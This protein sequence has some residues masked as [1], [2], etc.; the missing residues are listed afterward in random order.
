MSDLRT[1]FQ[2]AWAAALDDKELPDCRAELAISFLQDYGSY[3]NRMIG[4]RPGPADV[5]AWADEK[6]RL[7]KWQAPGAKP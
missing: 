4:P 7:G 2:I 6:H 5:A 1:S 3:L